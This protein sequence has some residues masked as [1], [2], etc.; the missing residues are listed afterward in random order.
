LNGEYFLNINITT[1]SQ[2]LYSP[3][4]HY[5]EYQS[6]LYRL[7]SCLKE[8]GLGYRKISYY[9]NERGFKTPFSKSP[10]QNSNVESLLRKGKVREERIKNIKSHKDFGYSFETYLSENT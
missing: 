5:N 2:L 4:G 3:Y 10:F 9:L 7:C 1:K 6:K 8:E